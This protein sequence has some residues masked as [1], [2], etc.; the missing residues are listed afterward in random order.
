MT[1]KLGRIY[2]PLIAAHDYVVLA[3]HSSNEDRDCYQ[4]R[5]IEC[6]KDAADHAGFDLVPK[7]IEQDLAA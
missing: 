5:L 4:K 7:K 3:Q 1:L 6:L 2:A